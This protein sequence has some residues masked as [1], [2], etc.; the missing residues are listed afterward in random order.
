MSLPV[1]SDMEKKLE[2]LKDEGY[3]LFWIA[4]GKDDFLYQDNL[5]FMK[6]C[7][8][9]GF[10]YTYHETSRGHIWANW[11]QYLLLFAPMLF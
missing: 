6:T 2:N 7:D 8:E 4:I 9:A 11:R 5:N 10:D 3:R 1:Y